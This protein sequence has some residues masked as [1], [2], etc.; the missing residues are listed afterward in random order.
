M[1]KTFLHHFSPSSDISKAP[2]FDTPC[3]HSVMSSGLATPSTGRT[4]SCKEP[5]HPLY[6]RLGWPKD[7]S[8]DKKICCPRRGKQTQT[9]YSN[10]PRNEKVHIPHFCTAVQNY[11]PAYNIQLAT[12]VLWPTRT[13]DTTLIHTP[14]SVRFS[15]TH[16]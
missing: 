5:W 10:I 7:W 3:G 8:R 12:L 2:P 15:K 4:I 6:R 11:G 16:I 14:I 13:E 9:T 1:D